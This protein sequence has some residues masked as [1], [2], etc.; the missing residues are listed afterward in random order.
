MLKFISRLI[1]GA[2]FIFSGFVKAVD[3][4]GSA[5]KIAE[6]LEVIGLHDS[7]GIATI[8]AIL[9]SSVE[10]ILGFHLLL[11][12]KIKSVALPALI[13]MVGFTII[14]FF[15]AIFEP[16]S[17]CGCFGDAIKLT[18]WETLTKNLI[19]LPFSMVVY[20][21]R[22]DFSSELS[23]WRQHLL[24][25]IGLVFIVGTSAYSLYCLP[26]LDFRPYHIGANI[27][28]S[29]S[30]PEDADQG[31]YETTF[32]LEKDGIQ[33][34]FGVDDYPYEDSTWVFIDSRTKVLRE[35]YQPPIAALHFSSPEGDDLTESI[36]N[37]EQ[38][39][40]LMVAPKLETASTEHIKQ[41][42]AIKNMAYKSN[43]QFYVATASL[44]EAC[45]QF[46]M[47]HLAGFEYALCDETTLKTI[48]R[49]NP[50]LIIIEKGTIIAK[51]NHTQ[52][53]DAEVLKNPLSHSIQ[54]MQ[55]DYDKTLLWLCFSV[56]TGVIIIIHK[57][58]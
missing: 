34:E 15:I 52:L 47:K 58:K 33:K 38:P 20:F 56:I 26:M 17:D 46:D 44:N 16:V 31:E 45:Y 37:N 4:K 19:I 30:I 32:I 21:K 8:L 53:P 29:M 39:V 6:Y 10:F 18:N 48:I 51:Y 1:T 36:I 43:A 54:A 25:F 35:G 22:K 28:E 12:F 7:S 11:G 57:F 42:I 3:P 9:L 50:G 2:V 14:T 24:T 55:K 13:F 40:F 27:P 49:A 23:K 41:F 5:I